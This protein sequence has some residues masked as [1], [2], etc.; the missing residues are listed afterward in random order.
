MGGVYYFVD[1]YGNR[2]KIYKIQEG[3]WLNT[4]NEKVFRSAKRCFEYLLK[5]NLVGN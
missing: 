1:K 2:Q 5:N 4:I 3:V